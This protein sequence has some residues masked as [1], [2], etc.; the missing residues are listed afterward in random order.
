MTNFINSQTIIKW[1]QN[2]YHGFKISGINLSATYSN[3]SCNRRAQVD[4]SGLPSSAQFPNEENCGP[5]VTVTATLDN[6]T[7]DYSCYVTSRFD[8]LKSGGFPNLLV[9]PIRL[10]SN[11]LGCILT[12]SKGKE[13]SNQ[14]LPLPATT[15]YVDS[16]E[17]IAAG[18]IVWQNDDCPTQHFFI[19]GSE[20]I[21]PLT[22]YDYCGNFTINAQSFYP[23]PQA[24]CTVES[25]K[26]PTPYY[27]TRI[28]NWRISKTRYGCTIGNVDFLE[29][30]VF[31][32][33]WKKSASVFVDWKNCPSQTLHVWG[34]SP[35][36]P[37]FQYGP[38]CD[39]YIVIATIDGLTCSWGSSRY[40]IPNLKADTSNGT[41]TIDKVVSF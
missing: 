16:R 39:D 28:P 34:N 20:I 11:H 33:A 32:G 26:Y 36:P 1:I 22:Y 17:A 15:I 6:E 23:L 29:F 9:I 37:S 12:V 4:T 35:Y 2:E 30:Y 5:R 19:K 38:Y 7:N 3:S 27:K 25:N 21:Q 41:C 24:N 10:G 18:S 8:L 40:P 31:V 14:I 13:F